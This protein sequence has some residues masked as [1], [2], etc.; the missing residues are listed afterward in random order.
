M[1][2]D[3]R[4]A[5]F[6]LSLSW[7]W[8]MGCWIC[9]ESFQCSQNF[10]RKFKDQTW[11][12]Y[13]AYLQDLKM[14]PCT[15]CPGIIILSAVVSFSPFS[16]SSFPPDFASCEG[17]LILAG[18]ASFQYKRIA[19]YERSKLGSL[20]EDPLSHPRIKKTQLC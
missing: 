3:W 2:Y 10:F 14:V 4:R 15:Y 11:R 19:S 12:M 1:D 8:A 6:T 7:G 17:C 18:C 20:E 9:S 5:G 16:F 13:V